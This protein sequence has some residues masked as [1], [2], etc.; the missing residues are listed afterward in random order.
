[1]PIKS[2]PFCLDTSS[3]SSCGSNWARVKGD[4]GF[5]MIQAWQ[6]QFTE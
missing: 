5:V 6:F 2:S 3:V 1:M 4:F